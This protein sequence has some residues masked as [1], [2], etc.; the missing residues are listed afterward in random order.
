M[1]NLAVDKNIRLKGMRILDAGCGTGV[2]IR[3]MAR[4]I[5]EA[6]LTGIDF[7][8]SSLAIAK[9]LANKEGL[10]NISFRGDD[11]LNLQIDK[12]DEQFDMIYSWG[13]LHHIRKPKQAFL[14]VA[15]LLALGG[16]FRC[17]IYGYYGNRSRRNL[18]ETINALFNGQDF[19][20]KITLVQTWLKSCPGVL[21]SYITQPPI[22]LKKSLDDRDYIAD[23]FLHPLEVHIKLEEVANWYKE[24]GLKI[25][26]LT[27]FDNNQIS[28]EI[29]NYVESDSAAR[30]FKK[31]F[32]GEVPFDAIDRLNR[33]YWISL[34][35]RRRV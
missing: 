7:T 6:N 5:P 25:V 35:G 11:L 1:R 28:L 29:D 27:D 19:Q 32:Q 16:L 15:K 24:A 26:G 21:D 2:M 34:I 8:E 23:E 12:N 17:G 4:M 20:K 13:V 30:A 9:D 18:R 31:T 3:D 33:P 10:N 22:D 14:N